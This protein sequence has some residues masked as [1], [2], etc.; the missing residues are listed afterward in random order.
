MASTL[1]I[2]LPSRVAAQGRP[3]WTT[4][5]LPFALMSDDGRMQQQG[6]KSLVELKALAVGV[7]QLSLLLAASDVSMLTVKVPPMSAAKFKAALPNLIEEQIT[8]DPA[9]A[10]IV[11]TAIVE[12]QA[13]AAVADRAWME[14]IAKMV[15]DWPVKKI[16]AFPAQL[17]M[18]YARDAEKTAS[19]LIEEKDGTRELLIRTGTVAG[20]G[21]TLDSDNEV[22]PMVSLLTQQVAT[23]IY[24]AANSLDAWRA[25][26]QQLGLNGQMTFAVAEWPMRV[27]GIDAQ[28]PDLMTAIAD[29][30]KAHVDW[31]QWRW[32][33]RLLAA[34]VLVNLAGL[35]F[36][37]FTMK[38][39]ARNLQ[40][41]LTQ[42]YRNSFPKETT[43]L[44]PLAQMQQKV[45]LSKRLSGQ[46]APDDFAVLAAQFAQTWDRV[47]PGKT[48]SIAG[49]EY[50]DRGLMVK[51][52]SSENV[53]VDQLRAA[54]AEQSLNI[55]S[56]SDGSLKITRG[57]QR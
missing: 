47:M 5:A 49:I 28:T 26:A 39:E 34:V 35:N 20:L 32:P 12:G 55:A 30:H 36:E 10:V 38:R 40:N 18:V 41:A 15:K 22:L 3:D 53:P 37:W 43:I 48:S 14:S 16:T 17:A 27:A 50:K 19:V 7:R 31:T 9:D 33:L 56:S 23:R 57:G 29:V 54:L 13:S 4:Q 25:S 24:V 2:S 8:C 46:L 11:A 1:Y 21:L 52:K 44:D 6:N 42:T 45:N 51:I